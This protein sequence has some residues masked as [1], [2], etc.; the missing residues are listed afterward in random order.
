MRTEAGHT[1]GANSCGAGGAVDPSNAWAGRSQPDKM[2]RSLIDFRRD[3][4]NNPRERR[5]V[6]DYL[7]VRNCLGTVNGAETVFEAFC[8]TPFDPLSSCGVPWLDFED[9]AQQSRGR[10]GLELAV[11]VT[12]CPRGC[13][14]PA[15]GVDN[16]FERSGHG[17]GAKPFLDCRKSSL[18]RREQSV[19]SETTVGR[20]TTC[21]ERTG[22]DQR[23]SGRS[24]VGK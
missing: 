13:N 14:H 16:H 1:Q 11:M 5:C 9:L 10:R 21:G 3:T 7:L 24:W 6:D 2:G 12:Q 18:T 22:W 17:C 15:E 4:R 19:R 8:Q 20:E 23:P